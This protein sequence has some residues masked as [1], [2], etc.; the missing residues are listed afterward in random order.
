MVQN[1]EHLEKEKKL[2]EVAEVRVL[3]DVAAHRLD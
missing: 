3:R 2:V 1:T